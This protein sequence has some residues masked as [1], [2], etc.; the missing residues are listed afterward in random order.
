M[1]EMQYGLALAVAIIGGGL[2]PLALIGVLVG[3][4]RLTARRVKSR[5]AGADDAGEG[6]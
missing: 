4:D 1:T 3:L 6:M 5:R 2:F